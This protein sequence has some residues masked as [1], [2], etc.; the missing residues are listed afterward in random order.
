MSTRIARPHPR[1]RKQPRQARSRATV[2]AIIEAAAHVLSGLGW[3]GFTTNKVAETAG[4]SIGTLY[5]Y[6]PD[7]LSLLAAVRR[8]HFDHV[9]SVIRDSAEDQKPL[10]TFAQ[11]LVRGMIAAHSIHPTLH[12]V[13]L[14]EAPGDRGSRAAHA[15]FQAQYLNHYAAAVASYRKP[16][17]GADTEA[18]ARVLSSAIE[19][20]IHNAARR[21]M[22]AA[23]E[24]QKQ[25]VELICAYL[26]GAGRTGR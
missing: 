23:P 22:L 15:S 18:V 17:K 1:M 14:D 7:K 8:R 24:L 19:G 25:L 20:V 26:S 4:V 21:N 10:R 2:E 12:Q 6:F 9:L 3:A 5:Q 16:R 11:E 13:L